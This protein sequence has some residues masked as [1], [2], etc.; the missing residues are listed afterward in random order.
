MKKN[1]LIAIFF[2]FITLLTFTSLFYKEKQYHYNKLINLGKSDLSEK[3]TISTNNRIPDDIYETLKVYLDKYKANL[4]CT[5]ISK[6][7]ANTVVIKYAYMTNWEGFNQLSLKNG[8]LFYNN[9]I[10]SDYF[11]ST[12]DTGEEKQIGQIADFTG[13]NNLEI[14]TLKNGLKEGIFDKVFILEPR[15]KGDVDRLINEVN[16]DS[17]K[18]LKIPEQD[19][20]SESIN[21]YYF[22][23]AISFMVFMLLILYDLL[24]SYKKIAIE[25][26]LG[27]DSFDIFSKRVIPIITIGSIVMFA[28]T[29]SLLIIN[30]RTVNLLFWRFIFKLFGIYIL[31][32]FFT[33]VFVGI[34]FLYVHKIK[35]SHMLKNKKPIKAII[36][37][38]SVMRII[39][40]IVFLVLMINY[41][42]KYTA[43]VKSFKESYGN[44]EFTKEYAIV[45]SLITTQEVEGD[46]FTE[47]NRKKV[48]EL[49]L[50]FN[51]QGAIYAEF[52][53]YSPLNKDNRADKSHSY[54]DFIEV[55][56]NYLEKHEIFTEKGD[57]VKISD[58]DE[59]YILLVPEKYHKY[60]REI[61][62]YH[63]FIKDENSQE[64]TDEHSENDSTTLDEK[65]KDKAFI[66]EQPIRIIWTSTGQDFFSYRLDINPENNNSIEDPV[67]RVITKS[68][69]D[70]GDYDRVFGFMGS[71]VKIRILDPENP[72][73]G[74]LSEIYKY[75]DST[76]YFFPIV[77]V[78]ESVEDQVEDMYKEMTYIIFI[79]VLLGL[80][81]TSIILQNIFNYFEEYKMHIAIQRFH[82]YKK[83]H[84]YKRY[85]FIVILS[86][87]IIIPLS[88]IISRNKGILE[89]IGYFMIFEGIASYFVLSIVEKKK[90]IKVTKGG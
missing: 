5:D 60:E 26:M 37:F 57:R 82:G 35:I 89:L 32:L 18:I 19:Y 85:F 27:Y 52:D 55:N 84:K 41:Y 1:I 76:K 22:V 33:Y 21:I 42:D 87:G 24:N 79:L 23:I 6:S 28:V 12:M 54:E 50:Y 88:M 63:K 48:K 7:G 62:E 49:Y 70:L 40:T 86:W 83:R 34:P 29:V 74:I 3:I 14:R 69:G 56:P 78:Y 43:Q 61:I 11:L 59:E 64:D 73:V 44:W 8:R 58:E 25:K 45:P 47:E 51:N 10:E 2:G 80:I 38:N 30:F 72:E 66:R 71:P 20:Y 16:N 77:Q 68:N 39:F 65:D 46:P 81:I 13:R 15:N 36:T 67:V 90:I 75:F 53:I 4:Y 17:F 9:E 31:M